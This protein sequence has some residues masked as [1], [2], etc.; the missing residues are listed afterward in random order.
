MYLLIIYG[1]LNCFCLFCA[2][3]YKELLASFFFFFVDTWTA[4]KILV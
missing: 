1:L 3:K 2:R 4:V